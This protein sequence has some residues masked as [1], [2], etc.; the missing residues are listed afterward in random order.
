MLRRVGSHV[1]NQWM[2]ALSLFLVLAGGTAYASHLVVNSSDI[3]DGSVGSVDLK[4]NDVRGADVLDGTL[5][6]RDVSN[7]SLTGA[8]VAND[9]IGVFDIGSQQVA[10]DEVLNDS[11]LQSDIRAGAVTGDEVLDNSVTGADIDESTLNMPPTTTATF[12]GMINTVLHPA[13][14]FVKL[15][16]KDLPRG[17]YAIVG[18]VNTTAIGTSDVSDPIRDLVCE[19]R[20]NGAFIGGATDRRHLTDFGDEVKRSLTMNGGAHVPAGGAQIGLYC[21]TTANNEFVD[22]GQLMV[23]RIDGFF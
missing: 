10:S 2:G 23:L 21:R 5:G 12:A 16:W 9:S 11:L 6:T 22:Y 13:D 4:N 7:N 15:G 3:V 19:L 8:D 20:N 18:T 1:R 17:N 14:G